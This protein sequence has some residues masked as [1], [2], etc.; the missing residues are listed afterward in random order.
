M[1]V[2]AEVSLSGLRE[3]RLLRQARTT[4]F[5]QSCVIFLLLIGMSEEYSHNQFMQAWM[6][7]HIGALGFVFNGTLAAFYGGLVIAYY[8]GDRSPRRTEP[9][10]RKQNQI[11]IGPEATA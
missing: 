11:L 7:Q 4:A 1:S 10:L 8:F 2:E 5:F 6:S 3:R 9:R